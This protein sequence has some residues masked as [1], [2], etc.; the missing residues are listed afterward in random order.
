MQQGHRQSDP[1]IQLYATL[2]NVTSRELDRIHVAGRN[3]PQITRTVASHTSSVHTL[4]F[5]PIGFTKF[6]Y[7][8]LPR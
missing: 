2:K 5:A 8:L 7:L 3:S 4:I 1:R 6:G